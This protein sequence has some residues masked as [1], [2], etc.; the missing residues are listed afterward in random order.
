M[1]TLYKHLKKKKYKWF[2]CCF[3]F[4]VFCVCIYIGPQTKPCR[5][6]VAI[7]NNN[8]LYICNCVLTSH[9][10]RFWWSF[11][12]PTR[13][14]KEHGAAERCTK[15]KEWT[16][17]KSSPRN[18]IIMVSQAPLP[19]VSLPPH[20]WLSVGIFFFFFFFFFLPFL[21]PLLRHM[22]VPRLGG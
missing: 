7:Y 11:V 2:V 21:G 14:G 3:L 18:L 9:I 16:K 6:L 19:F 4:F 13:G 17:E 10:S 12:N 22:E 8:L 20:H 5:F 15:G 1:N